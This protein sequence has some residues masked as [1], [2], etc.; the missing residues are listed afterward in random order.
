MKKK[1]QLALIVAIVMLLAITT[2]YAA[3][4]TTLNIQTNS[5][6]QEALT[7]NVGFTGTSATATSTGT[8]TT[9]RSCG[10]ATITAT[11]VTV[12][13]TT[14]SKP[15][16]KCVY[17]LTVKNSGTIPAKLSTITPTKPTGTSVTCG[18]ASGPTMVCGNITYKLTSNSA[19]T[20]AL[21]TNTTLAAN[22]TQTVYLVVSYTGTTVNSSEITQ[23]G[24]K[25]ALKYDQA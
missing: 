6:V 2:A 7:W 24:A 4:S 14:L 25:F 17:T 11:S 9:G 19:G 12:A 13:E 20:T 1:Y 18:T 16:D 23:S 5:V 8:S 21:A 3:L 22:G 10:T 15:D